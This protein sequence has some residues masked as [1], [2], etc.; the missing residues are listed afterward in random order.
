MFVG[1]DF[2]TSNSSIGLF[3]DGELQLYSLDPDN[4]NPNVLPSMIYIS[5]ELEVSVGTHAIRKYL[6]QETGRRPV[7]AK[8]DLGKIT[9]TVSGG[10]S[11]IIYDQP[12]IV[13]VDIGAK[14]RLLQSIKTA[15]RSA[16]YKGTQVF[17][18]YYA[19]EELIAILLTQLRLKCEHAAGQ[20]VEQAVIGRPVKFS[21]DPQTDARAQQKLL[22]AAHL[23]GF[24]E[25]YF[26]Y[27][28]VGGAYLYHQTQ[29][30]RQNTLIFDF[31]GG[32]LDMTIMEVGGKRQP[33][34]IASDG[35]LLGGDDL[36]ALIMKR[37]LPY[38][39][40][41]ALLADGYPVP[42]HI[43]DMLYSW[44]NM[45]ELSRPQY[46]NI[47]AQAKKGND[48]GGAKRLETLVNKKLGFSLFQELERVKVGL[49]SDYLMPIEFEKEDLRLREIIL[50]TQF[51]RLFQDDLSRTAHAI[52]ELLLKSGLKS[53]Q[54]H[55]VLRTGGSSEIPAFIEL[56]ADRFG[57]NRIK[58]INPF[59][60]IVGGLA[61]KG[62]EL[63]QAG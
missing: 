56:L 61:L 51:E 60:T 17:E 55:A 35:V 27:E 59:T 24:K 36:T 9:I 26:E 18:R 40:E 46:A 34:V 15:L 53:D 3:R 43:F 57:A 33:Q 20:V 45:V 16:D 23:A 48:P 41:G 39:G 30:E 62:H 52:D 11:P 10:K 14:G 19:I 32:T 63:S 7:W 38:F 12:V 6:E 28:P 54:I 47:I 44:Q 29:I 2:G 1:I 50:R 25:V 8:Q 4:L 58:E 21:D 42:A 22:E 37:L 13:D 31:G 5:R 49:S